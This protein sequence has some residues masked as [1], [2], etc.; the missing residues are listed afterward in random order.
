[1]ST[2]GITWTR[3]PA[4]TWVL[5]KGAPGKFD[6][7]GVG[8]PSVLFDGTT[9][10][11]WYSNEQLN[12]NEDYPAAPKIGYATSADGITWVRQNGGDA[13]LDAGPY[14]E[15]YFLDT[16]GVSAPSVVREDDGTYTM[17]FTGH[18]SYYGRV[19][20]RATSPD[21]VQWTKAPASD[22]VLDSALGI[23]Q[24]D[25]WDP[26]V[27]KDGDTYR[28]WYVSGINASKRLCYA[29]S[30]DGISWTAYP[31][32]PIFEVPWVD[33]WDSRGTFGPSAVK[34]GERWLVWYFANDGLY[35]VGDVGLATNP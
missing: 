12:T 4:A 18:Q 10:H 27:V 13:V 11:M 24:F 14:P 28:A 19:I 34:D 16:Y 3:Q 20:G 29:S 7:L 30:P 33:W 17:W 15:N 9:W 32:N 25:V 1:V 8:K 6:E 23:D 26:S 5:Q 35:T 21:G 2:D 31:G 22:P